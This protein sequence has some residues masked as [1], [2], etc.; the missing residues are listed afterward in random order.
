MAS[1]TKRRVT[2]LAGQSVPS[3]HD[4]PSPTQ[5]GPVRRKLVWQDAI[6]NG[7]CPWF[8]NEVWRD[9]KWNSILFDSVTLIIYCPIDF[10][11]DD[12]YRDVG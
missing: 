12:I 6:G 8:M 9:K 2:R 3:Y 7:Q 11:L 5:A 4:L 10:L 1:G